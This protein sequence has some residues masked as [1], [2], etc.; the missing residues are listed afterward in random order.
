MDNKPVDFFYERHENG[1]DFYYEHATSRGS[2]YFHG[3][4]EDQLGHDMPYYDKSVRSLEEGIY[5]ANV[6]DNSGHTLYLW[7]DQVTDDFR[8][9]RGL[10]VKDTDSVAAKYA[11]RKF[12]ERASS[13]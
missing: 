8:Q 9:P 12:N 11:A 13:L 2:I 10:I 1:E 6:N 5:P 7:F 4:L 3:D